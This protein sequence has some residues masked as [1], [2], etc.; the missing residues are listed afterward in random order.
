MIEEAARCQDFQVQELPK[1]GLGRRVNDPPGVGCPISQPAASPIY[2]IAHCYICLTSPR[3][4]RAVITS[5]TVAIAPVA[6]VAR[7]IGV[8][9]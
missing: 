1:V 6:R 5:S 7:T 4:W 3:F 8:T 9:P 2:Q